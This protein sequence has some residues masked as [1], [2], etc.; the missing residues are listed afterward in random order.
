LTGVSRRRRAVSV[1][2]KLLKAVVA[3]RRF[4]YPASFLAPRVGKFAVFREIGKI[5]KK[6]EKL[7]EVRDN[8]GY[9]TYKLIESEPRAGDFR[10]S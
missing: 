9:N 6:F 7:V 2:V 3:L 10:V 1:D 4:F 8:F 5:S